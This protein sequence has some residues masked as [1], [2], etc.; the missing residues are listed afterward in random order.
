MSTPSGAA[1]TI[2]GDA[3]ANRG[4]DALTS[5]VL[6]LQLENLPAP[7]IK[8][9]LWQIAVKSKGSPDPVLSNDGVPATPVGT[10]TLTM[11]ATGIHL[12]QVECIT[13]GGEIVVNPATGKPDPGINRKSR[14]VAIRSANGQRKVIYSETTQYDPTDG[15]ATAFNDVVEALDSITAGLI[16]FGNVKTALGAANTNVDMNGFTFEN[17]AN[18][19]AVDDVAALGQVPTNGAGITASGAVPSVWSVAAGAPSVTVL[20][21]A[22]VASA[23][24]AATFVRTDA[25]LVALT[26]APVDIGTANA[27][28][29]STA[30]ARAAHVHK[31]PF[32][33]V[34]TALGLATGDVSFNT[35]KLT[36]VSAGSSALDAVNYAQ[37]SALASGLDLKVEVRGASLG[38]QSLSG[39][40]TEDGIVYQTDDR[41]LAKNQTN[42]A[43][44]GIY[45]VDV[46]G[47]WSR[48]ADADTDAE[49]TPGMFVLATN[50]G[51]TN[52]NTGWALLTPG[53]ITVGVTALTFTQIFGP[54]TPVAGTG[55]TQSGTT[56]N[57]I[58]NADGSIVV[59]PNDIQVGI[60][61]TDAQ[62][63][64]RGGGGLHA[65]A[66]PSGAAGFMTGAFS[67]MLT[68]A[69]STAT[70]SKL[71]MW[72]ASKH[73]RAAKFNGEGTVSTAGVLNTVKNV[74]QVAAN[75]NA[76]SADLSLVST[77]STDKAIFGDVTNGAS[78]DLIAKSAG[79][80]R[81]M[82]GS[83][84]GI[85][86]T[87]DGTSFGIAPSFGGGSGVVAI[88]NRTTAPS[89][90]PVD[91]VLVYNEVGALTAYSSKQVRTTLSPES[92]GA[93]TEIRIPRLFAQ[94]HT[95][96]ATI[97]AALLTIVLP[98]AS[99][100]SMNIEVTAQVTGTDT[101]AHYERRI[102]GGRG[103]AGI[104]V[105]DDT[106]TIGT[107]FDAITLAAVPTIAGD[108]STAITIKFTGKAA[109][110]I[111]VW[112]FVDKAV[113]Y[114][115]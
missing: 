73:L 61:A 98:N 82:V 17:V 94:T 9:V 77:N 27:I 67:Q 96:N 28:G 31:L 57:V 63:G 46:A 7:D 106:L 41:Y 56:L 37:L 8:S 87:A 4:Y 22:G 35:H 11:P 21:D 84:V 52:G 85:H 12:Y 3:Y 97:T 104:P 14:M 80:V 15:W 72:D 105:I 5:E 76:G 66:V 49:V 43:E 47:A 93:A 108:G 13:N 114:A 48:S 62:H 65:N 20:T 26:A 33:A 44:N 112:I 95:N 109:T 16:T 54:G 83:F 70:A 30:F 100:F 74:V 113:V 75:N 71:V 99:S 91:C 2:T 86:T 90:A 58:A 64:S 18:G 25:Q 88:A 81:S 110:E 111:D 102:R 101:R 55:M 39:P 53:P 50:E 10:V 36:G 23:G 1:F 92:S 115:A 107:D 59:N 68:D 38:N 45:D 78:A 69:T 34:Q 19:V 24:A 51:T 60:L 40:L 79:F 29:I 6:T 103:G 89:T 42:P 32:S